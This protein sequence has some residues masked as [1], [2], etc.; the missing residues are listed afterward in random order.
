MWGRAQGKLAKRVRDMFAYEMWS[1]PVGKEFVNAHW[2]VY[3]GYFLHSTTHKT[4]GVI[5]VFQG[6][7]RLIV[8]K[9]YVVKDAHFLGVT[10][11]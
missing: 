6:D 1:L 3:T 5:F 9:G 7:T 4:I 10:Q 8:R 11:G 2:Q